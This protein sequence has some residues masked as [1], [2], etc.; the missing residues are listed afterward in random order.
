MDK[1]KKIIVFGI[2]PLLV[3]L[4]AVWAFCETVGSDSYSYQGYI[5]AIRETEDGTVLTTVSGDKMAEFTI[6][7]YTRKSFNGELKE[8]KEGVCIKLSTTKNSDTNIKKFSAYEGFSMEGKIVFMEDLDSPFILTIHKDLNYY[9]LY[10]LISAQ[11][12]AYPL[13]TGTQVK[14]YYQYPLN[15][16]TKTVVVDVIEP[17]TDILSPL[18]EKEIA[19]I[20]RQGYTVAGQTVEQ[21]GGAAQ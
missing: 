15:A 21:A 3:V 5:T 4:L 8:L 16:S 7:W 19:Y 13:Q 1:I 6:K 17:T 10:S 2:L 12:I 18:T 14:V 20:D 9:M 11:D